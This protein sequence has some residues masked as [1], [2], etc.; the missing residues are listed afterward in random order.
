MLCYAT[1]GVPVRKVG[2]AAAAMSGQLEL[3]I[4]VRRPP[5]DLDHEASV[6]EHSIASH[7]I[8]SLRIASHR[9]ASH[10]IA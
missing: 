7:R 8:A 10:S 3:R 9:I 1:L 6:Q 4:K 5:L 2:D